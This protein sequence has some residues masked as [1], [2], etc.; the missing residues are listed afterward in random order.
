MIQYVKDHVQGLLEAIGVDENFIT[1]TNPPKKEMGDIAFPVF[2]YAQ[3]KK[4]SPAGAAKALAEQFNTETEDTM[5]ERAEAFGPYVNFFLNDR[6]LA[7]IV[8]NL[9]HHIKQEVSDSKGTIL[10]E[11]ACPNTHKVFHIGHLRNVILG[12]SLVRLHEYAGYRVVRTNYQGD[13]GM[14]IAKCL[15]GIEKLRDEY[16]AITDAANN[17]R[18]KFIG[19]AYAHGATAFEADEAVKEEVR[20]YNEMIYEKNPAIAGVYETTRNWSLEYFEDIYQLL[21]TRFD[22]YYFESEVFTRAIDIVRDQVVKEV[23]VQSE[24]AVIFKG[25]EHDL[26]D[27]VF[28]TTAGFPTYEAKDLALAEKQFSEF[29]PD[30]I[31]HVIGPEQADYLKVLFKA[32]E[33]TLPESKDKEFHVPYGSVTLKGGKMSSRTGNVITAE[34]L[35]AEVKESV[36]EHMETSEVKAKLS[37]EE[38]KNTTEKV[39]MGAVKYAFLKTGRTSDIV[40]D[41]Q[42]SIS[43]SG[44]S[45]PYLLY[46]VAR[47]KSIL[48]KSTLKGHGD[49]LFIPEV[50]EPAERELVKKLGEFDAAL[51][52]AIAEK[53][54]SCIAQYQFEL[55]QAS[56]HFYHECPVLG[57]PEPT[58]EFRLELIRAVVNTME[59]GFDLLGI[60]TVEHM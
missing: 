9:S 22:R 44:D 18:M 58:Q 38:K 2:Q 14:H 19:K 6:E 25:S 23:F 42:E 5:V 4:M 45:G 46:I 1:L 24:G 27:R 56:N 41:M 34:D 59:R 43:T 48:G 32:L 13:V 52:A 40:F 7:R 31:Y 54:P 49:E 39:A 15:W 50:L 10:I 36:K 12:E 20:R 21:D 35:I 8:I 11:Y 53:D 55:S 37:A 29:H 17:E 47:F 60:T 57:S 16:D 30:A 28:L 33:F 3:E 26:H 51:E